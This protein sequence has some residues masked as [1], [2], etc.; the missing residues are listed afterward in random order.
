VHVEASS[1]PDKFVIITLE[2]PSDYSI[3]EVPTETLPKDWGKLSCTLGNTSRFPASLIQSQITTSLLADI[4]TTLLKGRSSLALKVPSALLPKEFNV[5]L[6][7]A[8]NQISTIKL[9]P[10]CF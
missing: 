6:N 10:R 3:Q 9:F 4:G 5:L 7:H 1:T 2:L 8:H